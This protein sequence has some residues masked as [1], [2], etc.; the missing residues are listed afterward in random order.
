MTFDKDRGKPAL[1]AD[2]DVLL[3]G[4]GD[5][6][7]VETLTANIKMLLPALLDQPALLPG[8]G[9]TAGELTSVTTLDASGRLD[10]ITRVQGLK[11]GKA[12]PLELLEI[13]LEGQVDADGSFEITAPILTRGK[14]GESDLQI[15]A[16]HTSKQGEN[17]DLTGSVDSDVF[18]LNDI[19]NTL[20]A[21]ANE[22]ARGEAGA[23]PGEEQRA[24]MEAEQRAGEAR[25]DEQAFWD[26]L[27][28]NRHVTYTIKRLFYTDYLEVVDITGRAEITPVR[29]SLDDFKA[30]F[31][32]SPIALNSVMTF[33]PGEKPYD[34]E[35]Q[36]SVEQFDL[37]AFLR[38]LDP[39]AVPRAEG[40]FDVK[41]DAN[42]KSPNMAQYR[43]NLYFDMKM[44]SRNG[45][46]RLLNPNDP[47]VMGSSGLAGTVGEGV[48]YLPTG[49][50]GLG[51]VAR[52][53]NYIDAVPYDKIDAHLVRDE[54]RDVQIRKY[55]VQSPEILM[56]ATGGI[57]Y[58]EDVDVLDSPLKMDA[59]LGLRDRGAAIFYDLDLL[60]DE[61]DA[62]G[63]WT[64]PEISFWG[65]M[66]KLDSNLNEIIEQAG[67]GAVLGGFTRPVSGLIGN[68]RH[69][70]MD[71]KGKAIEYTDAPPAAAGAAAATPADTPADGPEVT[72]ADTPEDSI[73]W[74]QRPPLE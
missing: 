64:G 43:N 36:A 58:E 16:V 1:D 33:T 61:Q 74:Y 21:I 69:R 62:Y 27:P 63:Y 72:P 44:Q 11:S 42:G 18:Y 56:T 12:L 60:G 17:D 66:G 47:L 2:V 67:K 46:F 54:S 31:H 51:A 73:M 24:A 25:P 35:M 5:A 28:Y 59:Q 34:L 32:D 50:F 68:V 23:E 45:V 19:L 37:N 48:S 26:T 22:K 49:L 38:A 9:L 39:E 20:K 3:K 70:W 71:E 10:S 29:L 13:K 53:V 14:S 40:L 30:Q 8:H 15:K 4:Q 57:N 41:L 55:V 6:T 52:M 7:R 65:T